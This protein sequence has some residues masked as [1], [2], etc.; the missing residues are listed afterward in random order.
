MI[1]FLAVKSHNS[2]LH[3]LHRNGFHTGARCASAATVTL[4]VTHEIRCIFSN[5]T[6]PAGMYGLKGWV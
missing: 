2:L 6:P 5:W 4:I 3:L 1:K